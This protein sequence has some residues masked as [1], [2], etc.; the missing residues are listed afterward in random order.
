TLGADNG[1]GVAAIMSVLE[2]KDLKH[3]AIEELFTIDEETG[4]TGAKGLNAQMLD[5]KVLLNLDSEEDDELT[6]GCAGGVD[7]NTRMVYKEV[8]VSA[9][10]VALQLNVRGLK[11]G[12]SGM[13][14]HKGR[15]NAN[16]VMNRLLYKTGE[17]FGMRIASIDGGS[18]RNAIPRESVAVITIPEEH[19]NAFTEEL[20]GRKQAILE[21]FKRIEPG[22][23]IEQS[24]VAMPGKVMDFADQEKAL[25]ALY[26]VPNGVWRMSPD[27]PGLVETSSSL[28]RVI[29]KEGAFV[30][31][32]L[33][34][35][36]VESGK[37][38][39][40]AAVRAAFESVGATVQNDGDY[41]GWAPNADSMI[42]ETMQVLYKELF[43]EAPK[44]SACHA[45]L[46]CGIL[47]KHLPDLDMISFGPTIH[48]A[49]SPDEQVNIASVQKFW[50]YLVTA[51]ER[52]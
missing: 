13:D 25:S 40:A 3:P 45:G 14:I 32:S 2:A 44:V 16:K 34:R 9:G 26:A 39:V 6:I 47:S 18:L 10:S 4:M 22:M 12:H 48:H 15:G 23:S 33:Q 49:H 36:S 29:I 21:E 42:M 7:S 50:R 28:A 31:Q 37:H 35:S 8:V 19:L 11:G 41:P 17:P 20:E 43:E 52:V 1:I 51:L 46:E 24:E 38:D 30:T 27:I 5:G